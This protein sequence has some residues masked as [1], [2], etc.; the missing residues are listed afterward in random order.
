MHSLIF[1]NTFYQ[2]LTRIVT[3]GIGFLITIIIARNFGVLG[4][5]E[6]TKVTAFVALFFLITDFGLNAIYLKKDDEKLHFKDLFYL[7]IILSLVLIILVNL[8]VLILP[9]NKD[10]DFGFSNQTKL[11]VFIFSFS[12]LFQGILYSSSAVFQKKLK[13]NLLLI[14]SGIGSFLTLIL[15]FI[16]TYFLK[17]V[18]GIYLAFIFGMGI[19]ALISIFLTGSKI[20]PLSLNL[21]FTKNLF[22]EALPI[23]LMLIFNLIYFRVDIFILSVFR[24][25]A[26]VGIYG[27]SYKFFDFLIAL[28][29]FLSNSI[30]PLLLNKK[31]ERDGF[32]MIVKKYFF[33]SLF[34]SVLL[35][36]L[37]WF[38]SPL[39]SF[40]NKEFVSSVIPFR[41]LLLSLP[42]FFTTSILQWALIVQGKQKFLMHIYLI[43]AI[44]NICLNIIFIPN[45]GYMASAIITGVSELIIF[46]FLLLKLTY[47]SHDK[48]LRV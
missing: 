16:D 41:I 10:S 23:G 44:I 28:P 47:P 6:F 13:Y 45:F 5:G 4:F 46:V 19:T 21:K 42:F 17:S 39:F 8:I 43:S 12:I 14:S 24:S 25:T 7:R 38:A 27:L 29:L 1:K 31:E 22:K 30:Y 48:M 2:T 18:L 11:G 26:E 37:F 32:S 3:S 40:I 33:I 20:T 9:Y 34:L 36:I 35:I 15:V